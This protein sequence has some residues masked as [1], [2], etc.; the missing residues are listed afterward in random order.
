MSQ[1]IRHVFATR[2]SGYSASPKTIGPISK[3]TYGGTALLEESPPPE[4]EELS[5]L[6]EWHLARRI[7]ASKR[8]S[9]SDLLPR[10]L[11]FICEQ[12]LTGNA[13]E[14]TEQ[15]IGTLIF[16]RPPD[17]NPGEDNIVR[18]YARLLRK[19][20]EEYFEGEGC[21]ES[22]RI[23]IPRGA[24]VPVFQLVEE[25]P[26]QSLDHAIDLTAAIDK[27]TPDEWTTSPEEKSDAD[28]AARPVADVPL[29]AT[30]KR[31]WFPVF[32]GVLAGAVLAS[33]A[34]LG[35]HS[36]QLQNARQPSHVLWAQLFG[37]DRNTLIVPADSGL[38]ILQNLTGHLISLEEY[39]NGNYPIDMDRLPGIDR[40]NVNDLRLQR[41]TSVADLQIAAKLTQLP[42]FARSHSQI[43]YARSI[44]TE[45][46]KTSNVILLGSSH[47]N[48]WVA[49]FDKGLNFKLKYLPEI[50]RS[51]VLNEHPA[52]GEQSQYHNGSDDTSNVTYGVIDYLPSLDGSGHV[53]IIQGLNMA[54]TQAAADTL[55]DPQAMKPVFKEAVLPN[56]S[57]R[58][59]ELLIETS[60]IGAT[61]PGARIIATRFYR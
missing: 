53:L 32:V 48:P 52:A 15:R 7:A 27:T 58:S 56:G 43:R 24:Y 30:W 36:Q 21:N 42:E 49:L 44:T 50:N 19:R 34:W 51:F 9:K 13:R 28:I 54:A 45:D 39:A 3:G 57:L 40:E 12:S 6:P 61:D 38:G 29:P 23:V 8:L 41:Y 17:Y 5:T 4:Q 14:I 25:I 10:F 26:A 35:F 1:D 47:T 37:T 2:L 59:F 46:L 60:S 33:F 20:L 55:F 11:L 18:S 16:N 31:L 22:M